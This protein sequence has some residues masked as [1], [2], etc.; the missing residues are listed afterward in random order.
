MQTWLSIFPVHRCANR[1]SVYLI[2]VVE[3]TAIGLA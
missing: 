1:E 3:S 2:S